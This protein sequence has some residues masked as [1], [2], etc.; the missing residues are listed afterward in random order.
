MLMLGKAICHHHLGDMDSSM[1][2]SSMDH[3]VLSVVWL[4]AASLVNL[5]MALEEME[6]W[7]NE[8]DAMGLGLPR[9]THLI[10]I[11]IKTCFQ[12]L[13]T[14]LFLQRLFNLLN[15]RSCHLFYLFSHRKGSLKIPFF[16]FIALLCRRHHIPFHTLWPPALSGEM[17]LSSA[18]VTSTFLS[19][20][21]SLVTALFILALLSSPGFELHGP[22]LMC[23]S[24]SSSTVT[25]STYIALPTLTFH[26]LRSSSPVGGWVSSPPTRLHKS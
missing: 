8:K 21:L 26:F 18:I 17:A 4:M 24:M 9:T 22:F 15:A 6:T 2:Y 25:D 12:A 7:K 20:L 10:T 16:F 19:I 14:Y 23:C 5:G 13:I 3:T 1:E 11:I